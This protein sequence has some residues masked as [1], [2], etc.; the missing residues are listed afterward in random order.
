MKKLIY[1]ILPFLIASCV[2]YDSDKYCPDYI[3]HNLSEFSWEAFEEAAAYPSYMLSVALMTDAYLNMDESEKSYSILDG[4]IG[5]YGSDVI[6]YTED[7]SL[8]YNSKSLSETGTV[9][10]MTYDDVRYEMKCVSENLWEVRFSLS[11]EEYG[12]C[13]EQIV[14][15]KENIDAFNDNKYLT[16]ASAF[17]Y[18]EEAYFVDYR[19]KDSVCT[20]YPLMNLDGISLNYGD[21]EYNKYIE[22]L[23]D[24]PTYFFDVE[25]SWIGSYYRH[26]NLLNTYIINFDGENEFI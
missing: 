26:E 21:A 13:P 10:T 16:V 9:W 24:Y 15:I 11:E 6:R 5:F 20:F 14:S 25:G 3:E 1:I 19:M 17:S 18:T 8:N 4:N 12:K 23:S 7:F 2:V 22:E